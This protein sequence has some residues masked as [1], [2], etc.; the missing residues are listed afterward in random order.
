LI[1]SEVR[2]KIHGPSDSGWK[3]SICAGISGQPQR[4]GRDLRS[5]AAVPRLMPGF[6]PVIAGLNTGM[7]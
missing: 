3:A 1:I 2:A 7:W 5:F 6:D 4:L